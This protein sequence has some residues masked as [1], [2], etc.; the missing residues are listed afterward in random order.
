MKIFLL[1]RSIYS[2]NNRK[3]RT[4]KNWAI[5]YCCSS[6]LSFTCNNV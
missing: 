2:K 5:R 6:I 3:M 1:V 4:T